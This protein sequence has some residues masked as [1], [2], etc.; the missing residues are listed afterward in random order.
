MEIRNNWIHI[1]LFLFTCTTLWLIQ[2]H[3][4]TNRDLVWLMHCARLML[5]GKTTRFPAVMFLCGFKQLE[6]NRQYSQYHY[7]K[8]WYLDTYMTDIK[9]RPPQYVLIKNNVLPCFSRSGQLLT[10]PILPFF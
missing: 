10:A 2:T 4:T 5:N 8:K 9:K 7:L 1:L 6:N 3:I